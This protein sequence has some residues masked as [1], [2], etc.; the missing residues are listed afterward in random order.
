MTTLQHGFI[1][2]ICFLFVAVAFV[3]FSLLVGSF[4]RPRRP[5]AEKRSVYECGERPVGRSWFNFT[6]RFYII[7]LIFLAF[8]VE[9]AFM[10]PV[11][12][13][14]R[15]WI[16]SGRGWVAYGELATFLLILFVGLAYVWR[17]GD[18]DWLKRLDHG[19]GRLDPRKEEGYGTHPDH[20]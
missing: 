13:V 7:G 2:V 6:P 17:K 14:Y 16:A 3:F 1:C 20:G 15:D 18:L 9:V 10:F 5:S 12:S 11:A 19:A 4:L 8:D